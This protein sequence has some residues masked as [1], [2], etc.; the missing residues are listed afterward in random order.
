MNRYRQQVLGPVQVLKDWSWGHAASRVFQVRDAEGVHWY[1]TQHR[2]AEQY[3]REVAAYR[4]WV[5][6]L[7]GRAPTLRAC[8]DGLRVLVLTAVPGIVGDEVGVDVHRQAGVLLRRLHDSEPLGPWVDIAAH[9]LDEL[10]TWAARA[11]GLLGRRELDFARSQLREL[12][13]TTPPARVPC[14]L[15]YSPRNWLVHAGAVHV[16]DFE[17][18]APQVW[19]NDLTRLF[20]RA[21]RD[22]PDLREAFYDGYGRTPDADE[23]A[24]LLACYTLAAVRG[25]VWA[26]D[27]DQASFADAV[28]GNLDALIRGEFTAGGR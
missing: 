1:V 26:R 5:P 6:A 27:H 18:A 16:V 13:G 19:V 7:G 12:D 14:H 15:D 23:V 4:R 21:W 3:H 8:D 28:A 9:K 25:L 2:Y 20:F 17:H 11:G 22:D 10:E 24:V